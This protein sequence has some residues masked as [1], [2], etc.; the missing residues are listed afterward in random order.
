MRSVSPPL[1]ALFLLLAACGGSGS[2]TTTQPTNPIPSGISVQATASI[3]NAGG[4]S[5][6][7]NVTWSSSFPAIASVSS[8][9]V[10]TGKLTG[11]SVI[12]ATSGSMHG[13]VGVTVIAGAPVTVTI[14]AGNDQ[15][16]TR[17]SRLSDP[18]CTTVK[19]AAGNLIFGAIVT[20][21]VMT[22]GGTLADPTA[23]STGAGAGGIA[24]SG[25]WTLGPNAGIQKVMA[26]S[27]GATSVTFTATAQ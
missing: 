3:A 16:A 14:Y 26:S 13:E 25:L 19:D 4:S 12:S 23:P 24:I 8:T 10:I 5:P 27:P 22:G 21:T 17:G 20:Y 7:T 9:G 6:A 18:L 1:G 2:G 15:S 11:T